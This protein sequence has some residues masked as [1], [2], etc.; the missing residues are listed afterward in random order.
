MPVNARDAGGVLVFG[1]LEGATTL[2]GLAV[3]G[4]ADGD[5]P[6][7]VVPSCE[8]RLNTCCSCFDGMG[9]LADV[10]PLRQLS[11]A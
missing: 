5:R 9:V 1:A 11:F 8:R 6:C 2:V 3:R 10:D 4:D 7:E